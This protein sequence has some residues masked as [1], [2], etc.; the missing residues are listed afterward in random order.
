MAAGRRRTAQ[1]EK[2]AGGPC[3]PPAPK[4]P[5]PVRLLLRLA[6]VLLFVDFLA[7]LVLLAIDFGLFLI[8][9][10]AAILTVTAD[11]LVQFGLIAF[12]ARSFL[13][14]QLAAL[15]PVRYALL[16]FF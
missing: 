2:R 5:N 14:I 11:F 12:D 15:H 9:Q 6:V 13:R 10:A 3:A 1:N 4:P 7:D 8:G 16:L